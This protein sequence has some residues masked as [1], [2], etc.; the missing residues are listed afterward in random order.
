MFKNSQNYFEDKKKS[1]KD[2][3][4]I[5]PL[6]KFPV[7]HKKP[8][9]IGSGCKTNDCRMKQIINPTSQICTQTIN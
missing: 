5:L 8:P 9:S 6:H 2:S 7:A 1:G 3:E 4:K